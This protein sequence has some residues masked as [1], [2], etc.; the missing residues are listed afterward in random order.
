MAN[1]TGKTIVVEEQK[2]CVQ[3]DHDILYFQ[4]D[5]IMN[6]F[7]H[8]ESPYKFPFTLRLTFSAT[9]F[10]QWRAVQHLFGTLAA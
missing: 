2:K 5:H 10:T 8:C 7:P 1:N 4:S 3:I 9:T 6:A